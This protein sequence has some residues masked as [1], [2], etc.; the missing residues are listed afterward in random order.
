MDSK[1]IANDEISLK[2]LIKKAAAWYA[3][4]LFQWK[5]IVLAGMIGAALGLTYSFIK[6]PV[7]TATLSFALEDEKSGGGGLGSALG[8]ASSL[9]LDLG[10]GGGSIFTGSNL[11]ELFK[12]RSMVE[13]TLLTPVISNGKT[14][15]LAEMYIQN[16]GWRDKWQGK[17]KFQDIQFL[18]NVKRKYFTRVHDSILGVIY[19]DLSKTGLTV[20][21][22]DKKIAIINIDMSSTNEMFA[23]Y[24]TEALAKQVSDFYITTKSKKARMNM[25]ILERQ[26][27]SI[28]GEL[29]GAITGVAVANDNTFNLN[30]A[31]NVRRAP[32][33]RRQVD[34]QA[35]TAILTELV[36]QT[37]MAK[38][39]LRK[40]TP[41]IQVIDRPIL[42]LKKERFGKGIGM[43]LGGFLGGFLVVLGLILRRLLR[44]LQV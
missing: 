3:Y 9:G 12:S 21:Q 6:K 24:F 16:E 4:L 19:E 8:L 34:V 26:T 22:K 32:S 15:S 30:P 13:Q 11:T 20:G 31:L 39:T 28:R 27:D 10:G 2:E 33:A 25:D 37:E 41:L 23:K 1:K 17:P 18:P 40:E 5:I 44:D 35:N 38:V 42:P 14:I 29:N 36:K 43:V 7:Y